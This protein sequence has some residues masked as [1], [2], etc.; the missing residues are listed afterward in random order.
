[1]LIRTIAERLNWS[2]EELE[3]RER[4]P[5]FELIRM[6]YHHVFAYTMPSDSIPS[7]PVSYCYL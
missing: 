1:M 5:D 3:A 7:L 6:A 2:A 4:H